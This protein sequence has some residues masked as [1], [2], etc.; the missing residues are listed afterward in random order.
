MPDTLE[1]LHEK[2]TAL[3]IE[4]MGPADFG[5]TKNSMPIA[6]VIDLVDN[7]SELK[8]ALDA[9][10]IDSHGVS[11]LKSLFDSGGPEGAE[12]CLT[13]CLNSFPESARG[14]ASEYLNSIKFLYHEAISEVTEK[15]SNS[16]EAP[17][18]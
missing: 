3:S 14:K 2:L 16:S 7:L 10:E 15:L 11:E 13:D 8:E 17:R 12:E 18:I 6:G 9:R 5:G 1:E 4:S